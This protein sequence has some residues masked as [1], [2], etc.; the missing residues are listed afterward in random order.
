MF[1]LYSDTVDKLDN[2]NHAIRVDQIIK[3]EE[4]RIYN[5]RYCV[6]FSDFNNLD[7][8]GYV[9]GSMAN[10]LA[11]IRQEYRKMKESE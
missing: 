2:P 6:I 11:R 7:G 5:K 9:D 4:A 3:V 1:I 8:N 10:L